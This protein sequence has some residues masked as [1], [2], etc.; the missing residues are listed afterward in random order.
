MNYHKVDQVR[1][2]D[3]EGHGIGLAIVKRIIDM[4]KGTYF[5]ENESNGVTFT[6]WIPDYL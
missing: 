4:H 2:R 1:G 6:I 5:V 3:D